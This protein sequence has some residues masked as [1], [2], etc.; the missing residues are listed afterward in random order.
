M[1][2]RALRGEI[3]IAVTSRK[4]LAFPAP[5]HADLVRIA[6]L[7]RP[8]LRSMHM[9]D[10]TEP[11]PGAAEPSAADPFALI[12][13]YEPDV[14]RWVRRLAGP[15]ADVEDIVHDVFVIALDRRRA[16]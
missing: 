2:S 11:E 4:E 13:Q 7:G 6:G 3:M 16:F 12:H 8:T 5:S 15:S 1:P 14:E 10:L 9:R